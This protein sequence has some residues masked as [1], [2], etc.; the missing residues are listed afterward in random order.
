[1]PK[2]RPLARTM[3]VAMEHSMEVFGAHDWAARIPVAL[4]VI[5]L[6][7]TTAIFGAWAFGRLADRYGRKSVYG[8]G[9]L[10]LAAGAR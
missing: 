8:W 3:G 4:E 5:A 7:W 10:V 2:Q 6:C 9:M 1:M